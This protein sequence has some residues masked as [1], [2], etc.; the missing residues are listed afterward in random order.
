MKAHGVRWLAAG[1]AVLLFSGSME[2]PLLAAEPAGD[3]R[4]DGR[5]LTFEFIDKAIAEGRL[6]SAA[7]LILRAEKRFPGADVALRQAELMLS[8]GALADA[9][10]AFQAL[11]ADEA[12][13]VRARVGRGITAIRAGHPDAAETLLADAVARDPSQ[14]RAWSARAVLADRRHDWAAAE[15]HYAAA[16]AAA[17]DAPEILNNRGYSRLL[18]GRSAE[19]EADFEAVLTKQPGL[20][21]AQTNLKLAK[22]MQGRYAEAFTSN[23]RDE[24]ARDLNTIGV[25]AMVRGDHR[26]AE[27]YFARAIEMNT[28]FDKTA[29]ANLAYL[30]TIA[31]ELADSAQGARP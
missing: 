22:A 29:T 18:Q 7:E 20:A 11:E 8:A 2:R 13:G 5:A 31:P 28:R 16:L 10:T 27:S 9:A 25:A 3:I 30:K 21:I 26:I 14:A 23:N 15:A 19:A 1:A 6:K 4:A 24:L 17:P 12:V